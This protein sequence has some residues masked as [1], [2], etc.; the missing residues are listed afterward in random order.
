MVT[1]I[2][3]DMNMIGTES[4]GVM[5]NEYRLSNKSRTNDYERC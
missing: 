2:T 3:M 1:G 5:N 4:V